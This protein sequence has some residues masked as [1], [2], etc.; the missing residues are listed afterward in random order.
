MS[1]MCTFHKGSINEGRK[2]FY[3]SDGQTDSGVGL[4]FVKRKTTNLATPCR[5][6]TFEELDPSTGD[7]AWPGAC[8]GPFSRRYYRMDALAELIPAGLCP[9][10]AGLAELGT[11]LLL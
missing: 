3:S 2:R 11:A 4:S 7:G 10:D 5:P 9:W 8:I 1:S 6:Q